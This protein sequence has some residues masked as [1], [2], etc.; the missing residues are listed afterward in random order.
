MRWRYSR[1]SALRR[2]W[3]EVATQGLAKHSE[4][5]IPAAQFDRADQPA[6]SVVAGFLLNRD[7][8]TPERLLELLRSYEP[9]QADS[10]F[11][12]WIGNN[13]H[14]ALFYLYDGLPRRP[15]PLYA[16]FDRYCQMAAPNLRFFIEFCHSALR[17][18]SFDALAP[19]GGSIE[20]IPEHVQAVAAKDTSSVLLKDIPN[21]GLRGR[22]LEVLVKRLGRLF[23]AAHRR[24]SL[25]EPEINHFSIEGAD[26]EALSPETHALLREA[27]IWSVLYEEVDT[28]NKSDSS[29]AQHDYVP[30]P[31]YSAH[32]GISYRKRRKM[33]LKAAEVNLVFTATDAHF[34]RFIKEHIQRWERGVTVERRDLF[35]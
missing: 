11:T 3:T 33:T 28:K 6:A 16:G 23:Q 17:E 9:A 25:S 14:G 8:P 29:L 20:S 12:D 24:A 2:R 26:K 31:I 7:T 10:P 15:N 21:L 27:L 5:T 34:E 18:A 4:V 13:L 1:D 32:F 35:E 30:N 22:E 19:T